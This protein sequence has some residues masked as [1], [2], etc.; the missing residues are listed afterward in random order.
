[1]QH[2]NWGKDRD[3]LAE[4]VGKVFSEQHDPELEDLARDAMAPDP[5]EDPTRDVEDG[6]D[7][8]PMRQF[9]Y[10]LSQLSDMKEDLSLGVDTDSNIFQ[11]IRHVAEQI[12][13]WCDDQQA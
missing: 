11:E 3:L 1:M 5:M 13:T 6:E 2:N 9:N 7:L 4:A 12:T 10:F 8:N